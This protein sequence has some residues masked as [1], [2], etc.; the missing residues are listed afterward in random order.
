MPGWMEGESAVESPSSE[1]QSVS[2]MD[3]LR[4]TFRQNYKLLTKLTDWLTSDPL[5]SGF[6]FKKN[7]KKQTIRH[8]PCDWTQKKKKSCI[9]KE[10]KQISLWE[11]V[12]AC[13]N[14]NIACISRNSLLERKECFV[15]DGMFRE[16]GCHSKNAN[17][18]IVACQRQMSFGAKSDM[19]RTL[20][21]TI[22]FIS[23][24]TTNQCESAK[25]M[26]PLH[27]VDSV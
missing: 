18:P 27:G 5:K 23:I 2:W 17:T 11:C 19:Y 6:L 1:I 4:P 8:F 13:E 3:H 15:T 25:L 21:R 16:F 7:E 24:N 10:N 12:C 14:L 20:T 22:W 26:S 9:E